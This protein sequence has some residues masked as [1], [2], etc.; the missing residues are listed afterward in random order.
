METQRP[1]IAR[2]ILRRKNKAGG[3]MVPDFKLYCKAIIINRVEAGTKADTQIKATESPEI[4][5]QLY[6]HLIYDKRGK[7]IYLSEW[8]S[9]KRQQ[10]GVDENAE[11]MSVEL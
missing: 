6:G 7:N 3:I 8:L 10:I 2:T 4:N 5:P 9:S 11:I 1:Q